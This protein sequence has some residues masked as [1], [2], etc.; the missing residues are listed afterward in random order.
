M[1]YV[2]S[3]DRKENIWNQME[4]RDSQVDGKEVRRW[5]ELVI[6]I[7]DK[8]MGFIQALYV[9]FRPTQ[10]MPTVTQGLA[11]REVAVGSVP[12]LSAPC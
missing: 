6:L 3:I 8:V 2:I 1:D 4:L 10:K 9:F 5:N 12:S 11:G 7:V